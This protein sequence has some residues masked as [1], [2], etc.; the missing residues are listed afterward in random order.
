MHIALGGHHKGGKF[1]GFRTQKGSVRGVGVRRSVTGYKSQSIKQAARN[2][3][4]GR[5]T[6]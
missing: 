5:S 3:R 2:F 1:A 6:I 4:A